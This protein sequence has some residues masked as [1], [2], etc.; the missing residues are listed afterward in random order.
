MQHGIVVRFG[1]LNAVDPDSNP[2]LGLLNE[3]VL[4][5]PRGKFTTLWK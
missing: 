4:S 1:G 5:D 2:G 3:F